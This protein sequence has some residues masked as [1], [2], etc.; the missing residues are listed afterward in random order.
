MFLDYAQDEYLLS[1]RRK[2]STSTQADPIQEGLNEGTMNRIA[3][4]CCVQEDNTI[5]YVDEEY[6]VNH[7]SMYFLIMLW[8]HS[9]YIMYTYATLKYSY[10]NELC[11]LSLFFFTA[12][13]S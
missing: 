4:P 3:D 10:S 13:N 5:S 6:H 7:M 1:V 11:V 9:I 12:N 8:L 2:A